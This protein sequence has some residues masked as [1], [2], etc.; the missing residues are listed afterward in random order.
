MLDLIRTHQL[1]IMLS[2]SSICGIII[3]FIFITSAM[4]KARKIALMITE[5]GAMFLLIFDRYAYIYR[6]DESTL[7]WW[8][9]RISNFLVF[10]LTLVAIWGFNL[11]LSDMLVREGGLSEVPKS[12]KV[13]NVLI[14]LGEALIIINLFTG[15]LY[16]FDST[17]HY[18]RA[19]GYLISYAIPLLS[20][21][22]QLSAIIKKGGNIRMSMRLPLFLFTVVPL[23]ASALQF[24]AYGLS[25][26]NMAIVGVEIIMYVFVVL[27]M[28]AAKEAKEEAEYENQAK[29]AF[30]A[31]MSHEIRTPINAVLGMNEMILRECEDENILD[32]SSNIKKAGNT[33]LGL[34]NDILDF[35][36]IEAGKMEII[37]VDYDISSLIGDLVTMVQTKADD[38]GLKLILDFD[39]TLPK[40]L[41][42]D[43]IRIKQVVTNILTNAVKYTEKGSVTFHIGYE[44]AE[45]ADDQIILNVAIKD[46]GIGI[47]K[48]DL[49]KLYSEFDRIEEKRNRNI[50]GTGLGMSI[51]K[52]LLDMMDSRLMVES[53]YGEGSVF[54]FKLRQKVL[55]WD[56][57]GDYEKAYHNV[58]AKRQM[59]KEKFTAPNAGILVLD[60]NP[61]NLLVFKNLIKQTLI[62][63]DTA[64]DAYVGLALTR[65]NKYDILF[66]D[67]LMPG[68]DGIEALHE[69][70]G[71]PDNPNLDTPVVCLTANAISGARE[72]YI[73]AGFT[74]YLTKPIN[75]DRLEDLL[76]ELLPDDLIELTKR[77]VTE[78][79]DDIPKISEASAIPAELAPLKDQKVID[80]FTGI[81]NS[82]KVDSYIAALK[83]F[84]DSLGK[85]TEELDNSLSE[86]DYKNYTIKVHALKS[87][88]KIIGASE[89]GEAAQQLENAGKEGNLNH[90]K[91]RH[92]EF[93]K[94]CRSIKEPLDGLFNPSDGDKVK[95]SKPMASATFVA[96]CFEEIKSAA[97]EMS[98]ERLEDIFAETEGYQI[99]QEQK[100]LYEKLKK[101]AEEFD[102]D[103][104]T[105]LLSQAPAV[106]IKI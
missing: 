103:A 75:P 94:A 90:I 29:S 57:L 34:I 36:K 2:L 104:I 37:P 93:I 4:P 101:A 51:T 41:R 17:N 69:L 14:I 13:I 50:E 68:K 97:E 27:D 98:C 28:N 62:S 45:D 83:V 33:L 58:L 91:E 64:E 72:E 18:Q 61:M 47:K 32:Y 19:D 99:P 85:K 12:M 67:H 74:D 39:H 77:E 79:T 7:G 71:E 48:E 20:L 82:G 52:R 43:E 59:Y 23:I 84:Y 35:S 70:R 46:T 78:K 1:N 55:K 8:M 88:L 16:T 60:D 40:M 5:S 49:S 76:I 63:V 38:K 15:I 80:V 31:N 10:A 106:H 6:G 54:A 26:I 66:F 11:Y 24:V 21:I 87:S 53:T 56:Q 42:G 95:N 105:E 73:S 100:E 30:L 25:L 65:K 44:R 3:F 86:E 9:V 89:L 81:K 92:A 96:T 102:Y 22:I